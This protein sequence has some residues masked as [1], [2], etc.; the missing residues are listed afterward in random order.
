M[1]AIHLHPACCT[2]HHWS[3]IQEKDIAINWETLLQNW[4]TEATQAKQVELH[5]ISED[6]SHQGVRY[7]VGFVLSCDNGRTR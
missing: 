3:N 5:E 7:T 1:L 2:A 4:V 6:I